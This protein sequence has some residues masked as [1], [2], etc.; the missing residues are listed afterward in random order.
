M[1]QHE[2]V[3]IYQLKESGLGYKKI[4]Q[5]LNLNP[6]TVKSYIR[7]NSEKPPPAALCEECGAVLLQF[8]HSKP[9]RFCSDECR[10][11]WWNKHP[12]HSKRKSYTYICEYCGKE[13]KSYDSKARKYCSTRCSADAR[14]KGNENQREKL[15]AEKAPC[16]TGF[17]DLPTDCQCTVCKWFVDGKRCCPCKKEIDKNI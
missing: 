15:V 5:I 2:K 12:Q 8:P 16:G 6:E 10:M 11:K 7:R 17:Q 1:T 4:A 3:R 9:K 14:H 13:F